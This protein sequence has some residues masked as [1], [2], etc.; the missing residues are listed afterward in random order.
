MSREPGETRR[1]AAFTGAKCVSVSME[2]PAALTPRPR[3]S[4]DATPLAGP[5]NIGPGRSVNS[6]AST[7]GDNLVRIATSSE[8]REAAGSR[9]RESLARILQGLP[10]ME[11][12]HT[13]LLPA[14]GRETNGRALGILH[15]RAHRP[16]A[17]LQVR[18]PPPLTIGGQLTPEADQGRSASCTTRTPVIVSHYPSVSSRCRGAARL[19]PQPRGRTAP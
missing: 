14:Y 6:L 1:P 3:R 13:L 11:N 7:A 17:S 8:K 2:S 19:L 12:S 10:S 16:L 18:T 5:Q 15:S 9:R 4:G